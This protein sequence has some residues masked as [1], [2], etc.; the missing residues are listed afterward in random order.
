[1]VIWN[2]LPLL[3]LVVWPLQG[4]RLSRPE[5]GS[6]SAARGFT[7][8]ISATASRGA[9]ALQLSRESEEV[10][11]RKLVDISLW[12]ETVPGHEWGSASYMP[13]KSQLIDF[14]GYRYGVSKH[15]TA[16]NASQGTSLDTCAC[17]SRPGKDR[18][19]AVQPALVRDMQARPVALLQQGSSTPCIDVRAHVLAVLFLP[20]T[21]SFNRARC[22][23]AK[24]RLQAYQTAA[25]Q[26][27]TGNK[28]ALLN[29][30]G[31]VSNGYAFPVFD[32]AL[33]ISRALV[34][35][36]A[37]CQPILQLAEVLVRGAPAD[38]GSGLSGHSQPPCAAPVCFSTCF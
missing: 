23:E 20:Q 19:E 24:R 35:L 13:L 27:E 22:E 12:D 31:V 18:V 34:F 11:G 7:R 6:Q 5:A 17:C 21:P 4:S 28:L 32:L 9:P 8:R 1:M 29:M 25:K 38:D 16:L 10:V 30:A 37:C 33:W 15:T 36:W 2:L 26:A 3:V 14:K